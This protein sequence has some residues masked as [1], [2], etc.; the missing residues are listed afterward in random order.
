MSKGSIAVGLSRAVRSLQGLALG[1]AFGQ[2]F[3]RPDALPRIEGRSLPEAPWRWTDDTEMALS[4]VEELGAKGTIDPDSLARR[5]ADRYDSTRGYG[6][7]AHQWMG[8]VR[9]GMAWKLAASMLFEGQGSY[10]NGGAMRVAPLGA[11][12]GGDPKRAA[13][14]A[15]RSAMVTHSH[16]E[17]Q[18]GAIAIAVAASL[19]SIRP[20]PP[21]KDLLL[22]VLPYV[23]AGPTREGIQAALAIDPEDTQGAAANL[24]TGALVSSQDT[25]PFALFCAAHHLTDFRQA[26][27]ETV[28]GLGDRDTTCAM[29][30]GIVAMTSEPPTEWLKSREP[31]PDL[32]G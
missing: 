3:F 25:V 4:V 26:M 13:E 9:G 5:F 6:G 1:D 18:A 32:R 30:G 2:R 15:Q 12:F 16:P 11:Y 29:V 19:V 10:G 8:L 7:G 27:W 21:G 22:Q 14:E 28:S 23:P 24:G 20:H 17:G 31:L